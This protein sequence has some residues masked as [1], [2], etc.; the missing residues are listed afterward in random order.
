LSK[1]G[2]QNMIV[3]YKITL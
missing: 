2:S 3:L 1:F